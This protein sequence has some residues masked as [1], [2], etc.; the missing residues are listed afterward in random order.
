[1]RA[2]YR[3]AG[4]PGL[5]ETLQDFAMAIAQQGHITE[6]GCRRW[7]AAASDEDRADNEA[8]VREFIDRPMTRAVV[9]ALLSA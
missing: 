2:A 9:E 6:L 3:D 5:V 7:L 4:G 8:W 1:M